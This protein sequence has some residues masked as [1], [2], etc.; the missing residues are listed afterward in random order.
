MPALTPP[1]LA[2]VALA[3][4]GASGA[5]SAQGRT[6]TVPGGIALWDSTG[7]VAGRLFGDA[8][9]LVTDPASGV[10]APASIR[11]VY[12]DDQRT[13]SG[14]ATW[15][16]G[17]SVLF[18]SPDC[19]TGAH[20]FSTQHAGLRATAQVLTAD[21]II[22]H[23]GALGMTTTVAVRSILYDTGCAMVSVRQNGLVPV[24]ATVNLTTGY[25]PPLSFR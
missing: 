14:W 4:L 15:Q 21:G 19:T 1:L 11:P 25:P 17:G 2:I 10:V 9:V 6:A 16:S 20:V 24:D 8:V 18:T 22:L 7:K 23:A 13:A 3:A 5:A 12:G